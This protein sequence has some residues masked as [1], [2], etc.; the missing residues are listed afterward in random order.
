[1][2]LNTLA[3]HAN[4]IKNNLF[5]M[6]NSKYDYENDPELIFKL[7]RE[8]RRLYKKYKF[9]KGLINAVRKVKNE[10]Y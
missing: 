3:Q 1:M 5:M 6:Q 10:N 2:N 8:E 9:F 4:K 7:I